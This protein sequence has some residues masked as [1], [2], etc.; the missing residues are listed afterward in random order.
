MLLFREHALYYQEDLASMPEDPFNYYVIAFVQYL[1]SAD[2]K[3]DSDGASSFLHL[4]SWLREEQWTCVSPENRRCL[5]DTAE[6]IAQRQDYFDADEE[7]Y[8]SFPAL[9]AQ[10]Q[11]AV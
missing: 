10:I 8:G 11:R 2:G 6:Y 1:R 5:L 3:G 9:Y 4:V 7:I